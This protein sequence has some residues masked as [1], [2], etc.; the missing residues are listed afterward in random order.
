MRASIPNVSQGSSSGFISGDL[1]ISLVVEDFCDYFIDDLV[2]IIE[3]VEEWAQDDLR[4]R[5][6]R[7]RGWKQFSDDLHVEAVKGDLSYH[8]DKHDDAVAQLEFG[9]LPDPLIRTAIIDQSNKISKRMQKAL[10]KVAP[11]A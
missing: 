2:Q 8:A 3:D 1:G 9:I 11:V 10:D 7:R 5:A 6:S 4:K